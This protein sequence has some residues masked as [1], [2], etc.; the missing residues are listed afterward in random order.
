M[1]FLNKI[2]ENFEKFSKRNAFCIKERFFTYGELNEVCLRIVD[3][4]KKNISGIQN[5]V[6]IIT[7]D[8]LET[9]ASVLALW[10]TENIF[11]PINPRNPWARNADIIK[12]AGINT[13][14]TSNDDGSEILKSENLKVL[15]TINLKPKSGYLIEKDIDPENILYLLFTSGSTGK[16]KGVPIS[17]RIF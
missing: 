14:L 2:E 16:P 5:N 8:D 6:G 3:L 15:K 17:Y 4:L 13:I 9:Y 10:F 12:Q 1:N 7:Y 11:V